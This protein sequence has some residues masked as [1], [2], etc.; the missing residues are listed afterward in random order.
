MLHLSFVEAMFLHLVF[1]LLES[2]FL[3][4]SFLQFI[5]HSTSMFSNKI[6]NWENTS[7]SCPFAYFSYFHK[8][9]GICLIPI[10]FLLLSQT[11]RN[12]FDFN[13]IVR[14]ILFFFFS[15]LLFL[16]DFVHCFVIR[17][18]GYIVVYFSIILRLCL[19]VQH[20]F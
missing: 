20:F 12:L 1:C 2:M 16:V 19:F 3:F 17:S 7:L 10:I 14:K 11:C 9:I 5:T 6:V 13:N 18:Y 4:S 15:F 8:L